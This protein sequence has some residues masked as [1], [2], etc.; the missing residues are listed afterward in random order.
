MVKRGLS[1]SDRALRQKLEPDPGQPSYLLP[2]P[3][4]GY[5]L[6]QDDRQADANS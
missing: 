3:G 2:E 1:D 6:V 5:R 4:L